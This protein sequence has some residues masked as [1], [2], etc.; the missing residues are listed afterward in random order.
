[1][2]KMGK[3]R[4]GSPH[5]AASVVPFG[6]FELSLCHCYDMKIYKGHL[7]HFLILLMK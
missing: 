1:M 7:G 5:R 2:G 4:A 3:V 6:L